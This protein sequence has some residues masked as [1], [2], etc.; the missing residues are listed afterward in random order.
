MSSFKID[1]YYFQMQSNACHLSEAVDEW[2]KLATDVSLK[3][4][5]NVIIQRF[6]SAMEPFH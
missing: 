5:K 6:K 4:Y 3:D 2:I 1:R